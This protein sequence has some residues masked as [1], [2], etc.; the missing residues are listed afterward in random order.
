MP[1]FAYFCPCI[2]SIFASIFEWRSKKY[3]RGKAR[4]IKRRLSDPLAR[5]ISYGYGS[6]RWM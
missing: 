5:I 1:V 6:N 4:E 3:S 2:A